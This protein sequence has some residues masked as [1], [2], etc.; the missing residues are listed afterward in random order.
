MYCSNCGYSLKEEKINKM[1]KSSTV[2][3][4][5]TKNYYV[6]PRCGH[7]IKDDLNEEEIKGLAR[8]SHAEIH[9]ARNNIN[10]GM[11]FLMISI[12]IF[13][14]AIMFFLMSFKAS[15]GGRL[16]MTSTE[17]Y[18]FIALTIIGIGTIS[19]SIY[20][21]VKGILRHKEYNQLLRNIQ[22]EIFIQ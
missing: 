11:C 13:V 4:S 7:I 2:V 22:N 21:L 19:Y 1:K 14:I 16:V 9:R 5:E 15:D 17:F 12:I 18:V 6:C 20:N 3:N 8:A 10:S